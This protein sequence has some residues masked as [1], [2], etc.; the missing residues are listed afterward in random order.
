LQPT[1]LAGRTLEETAVLFDGEDITANME[2]H[3]GEAAT[4]TMDQLSRPGNAA[5][6]RATEYDLDAGVT[7]SLF[8]IAGADT[9]VVEEKRTSAISS[10]HTH[11]IPGLSRADS[12]VR[13]SNSGNARAPYTTGVGI[14]L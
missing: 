12:W 4:I 1:P 14:A 11:E 2:H 10:N 3:A 6:F 9:K 13:P 5:G 7:D 8:S